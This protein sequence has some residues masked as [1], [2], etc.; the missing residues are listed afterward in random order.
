MGAMTG[1]H[2]T[3]SIQRGTGTNAPTRAIRRSPVPPSR[4]R[5]LPERELPGRPGKARRPARPSAGARR[6]SRSH[7]A[8][9]SAPTA[10]RTPVAPP[11]V[12]PPVVVP[13]AP[14]AGRRRNKGESNRTRAL[15]DLSRP[16]S[17]D[18]LIAERRP[19]RIGAGVIAAVIVAAIIAALVVLPL[20]RWWTQR[21]EL[22][23]R[24]GEL[25]TLEEA[26]AQLQVEVDSLKTP[27]GIEE[28]ARRELGWQFPGEHQVSI[29]GGT[30][31]PT[32]LPN[33]FPYSMVRN[34]L[35][36]RV[37]VVTASTA[38]TGT[39]VAIAAPDSTTAPTAATP[40]P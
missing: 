14:R 22:A 4:R 10:S 40:G 15:S 3:S 2:R 35:D 39:T 6:G 23:D 25:S 1:G 27:E 9:R 17:R 38:T 5:S 12:A 20:R 29:V 16:I 19:T 11:P 13:V 21:N 36:A 30:G 24:R 33:G 34:L 28:A 26:N 37:A 7:G 31:T 8:K 32:A 18:G